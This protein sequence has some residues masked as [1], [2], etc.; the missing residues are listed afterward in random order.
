MRKMLTL[1]VT[2]AVVMP[3]AIAGAAKPAV[4]PGAANPH[5]GGQPKVCSA[6]KKKAVTFIVRGVLVQDAT[7]TELLVDVTSVNSHA[8]KALAGPSARGGGIYSV[9][10]LQVKIDSCTHITRNGR[11]PAKRSW[12][13][14]KAGD[15][16]V[17]AFSAK[18]GTAYADLGAAR[19][20]VDRGPKR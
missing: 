2:A 6:A 8:K 13:T 18:R 3:V 4:A 10:M 1:V 17:V 14:L 12:A 15:R 11:G 7:A 5:K 9:P 16:V 20:V 19:R